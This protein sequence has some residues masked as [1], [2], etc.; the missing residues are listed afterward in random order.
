MRSLVVRAISSLSS[1]VCRRAFSSIPSSRSLL[2]YSVSSP[3]PQRFFST[4]DKKESQPKH[5]HEHK[6]EEHDKGDEKNG[7]LINLDKFTFNDMFQPQFDIKDVDQPEGDVFDTVFGKEDIPIQVAGVHEHKAFEDSIRDPMPTDRKHKYPYWRDY[8]GLDRRQVACHY[9]DED[10]VRNR[11]YELLKQVD[12]VKKDKIGPDAH[13]IN[14]LGLDSLD[15][16]EF[17]S[18][19]ELD[20]YIVIP[21]QDVLKFTTVDIL[22][23][24]VA[25]L[26]L[27]QQEAI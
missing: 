9:V 5:E 10:S 21:D 4:H 13:F 17:I 7:T 3:S 22:T 20:F 8:Y 23:K 26:P 25:N 2:H 16:M 11:I 15:V 14:D 1:V 24:Y 6:H 18:F 19:V 12:K 27:A